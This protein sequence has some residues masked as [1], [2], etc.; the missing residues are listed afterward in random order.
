MSTLSE[1]IDIRAALLAA[2]ADGASFIS[3][4]LHDPFGERLQNE[5]E[6]GPFS[7]MPDRVGQVTQEV[8]S[9][10]A[11]GSAIEGFPL[12][13][14]LREDLVAAVKHE[15]RGIKGVTTWRPNLVTVQRFKAEAIGITPHLDGKR[16]A[17]LVAIFTTKGN[18]RFTVC[19][20]RKGEILQ[21]WDLRP[22]S[23]VLLRAPGFAGLEDG[24]PFHMVEGP[25]RG[26]RY[27]IAFRL[28]TR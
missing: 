19:K 10:I 21:Q 7:P 27:S 2:K 4:A 12:L 18:A 9:F 13:E 5:I 6:A 28:D 24:R 11:R 16:F 25:K 3:G 26:Q 14:E 20:S 22:G 23:L 8:D 15:G 17:K 1:D